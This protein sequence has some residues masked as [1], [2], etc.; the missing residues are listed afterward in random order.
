[1]YHHYH[2]HQLLRRR[3][4]GADRSHEH[5]DKG[6]VA[7]SFRRLNML[8]N[9]CKLQFFRQGWGLLVSSELPTHLGQGVHALLPGRQ[10]LR[11]V[12]LEP[13]NESLQQ[14]NMCVVHIQ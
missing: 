3:N 9:V 5:E 6:R 11:A 14:Y 1:M 8:G 4:A 7:N 12:L 2:H 13:C 10:F